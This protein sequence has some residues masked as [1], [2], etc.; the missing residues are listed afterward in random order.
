MPMSKEHRFQ[1]AIDEAYSDLEEHSGS[2]LEVIDYYFRKFG[3]KTERHKYYGNEEANSIRLI[4]SAVKTVDVT[5]GED[6]VRRVILSGY[7]PD[8]PLSDEQLD[9]LY[10]KGFDYPLGRALVRL[11]IVKR[12]LGSRVIWSNSKREDMLDR[13]QTAKS[14]LDGST[15]EELKDGPK[16]VLEEF[17]RRILSEY[18]GQSNTLQDYLLRLFTHP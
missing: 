14:S 11:A 10:S 3:P 5:C 12:A 9:D 7:E 15:A 2:R 13:L 18:P 6:F 4:I 1:P 8:K 16:E 17:E